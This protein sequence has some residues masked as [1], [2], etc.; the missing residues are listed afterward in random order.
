MSDAIEAPTA[1][2]PTTSAAA[3]P[4]STSSERPRTVATRAERV[5]VAKL[6]AHTSWANT[7]DRAA[8]TAPARAA[9]DARFERQV[10]PDRVLTP[11]ERGRRAASARQAYYAG[12]AL[13]SA[14]ARRARSASTTRNRS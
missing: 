10:D 8:R 6:A 11:A 3:A 1:E 2:Q 12:L 5:L 9:L 7:P 4:L 14:Q 13:R